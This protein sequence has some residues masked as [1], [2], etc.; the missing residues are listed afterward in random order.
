M[1]V[2]PVKRWRSR[3]G[4]CRRT[5]L[6]WRYTVQ[7]LVTRGASAPTAVYRWRQKEEE[8]GHETMQATGMTASGAQSV[9]MLSGGQ[10]QRAWIAMVLAQETAISCSTSP[11]LA[12]YQSSD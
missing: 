7:E 4:C 12:G 1:N 9:D 3:I 5:P 6:R 2:T 11:L 8:G 10:R